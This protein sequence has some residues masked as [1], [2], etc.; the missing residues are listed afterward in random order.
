[1]DSISILS[2]CETK[3]YVRIKR[4][5]TNE[6][7]DY[8]LYD[9][10]STC[11]EIDLATGLPVIE[12]AEYEI[13]V[14]IPDNISDISIDVDINGL[15]YIVDECNVD[16]L[17]ESIS[18]NMYKKYLVKFNPNVSRPFL[19][20]YGFVRIIVT[21]TSKSCIHNELVLTTKD[22]PSISSEDYQESL[23]SNM[24]SELLESEN[25]VVFNWMFGDDKNEQNFFSR[26]NS[27]LNE[28]SSKSLLSRIQ[29]FEK[30]IVE[31]ESDFDYFRL[32]GFS[33][34]IR[35]NEKLA[36][37]RIKR[38]GSQE[39][40]WLVK[41]S[42]VLQETTQ[43]TSINYLGKYYLPREIET[44]VKEKSY[45]SYENRLVLG[46]LEEL[47]I[48]AKSIY[49]NLKEKIIQT[50]DL[51]KQFGSFRREGFSLPA[52]V[53]VRQCLNRENGYIAKLHEVIN[54]LQKLKYKYELIM[55]S[56]KGVFSR[57]PRRTKVFQEIKCYSNIYE[58][59][60]K[61]LK[62]GDFTLNRENLA[63]HSLRLD[64][65]YEYYVLFKLLSSLS[66]FGFKE[67]SSEEI[68]I[69]RANYSLDSKYYKNEKRVATLYKLSLNNIHIKLYY[70]PVVYGDEREENGIMLHRLS[71]RNSK[72]SNDRDSY[73]VPDFIF[74]ITKKGKNAEWHIFDAKY[75]KIESLWEG[76]PKTGV[77]TEV[78]S[79]YRSD[80]QP[81]LPRDVIGSVWLFSGRNRDKYLRY[82]E[83]SSWA[84]LNFS[85]FH[86]GIGTL[87]P[88]HSCLNHILLDILKLDSQTLESVTSSNDSYNYAYRKTNSN[89]MIINRDK[90]EILPATL[91]LKNEKKCN[92]LSLIKELYNIIE[93][94][95][96]L[97]K[98]QWAQNNLGMAHPL[99][100]RTLPTGSERKF[101]TKEEICEESCFVFNKW[102]PNYLNKLM[103]YIDRYK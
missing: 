60:L 34:I 24:L 57:L 85:G 5:F 6:S 54:D 74:K 27:A 18:G 58:L 78:I 47:I 46:F 51:E 83:R 14:F 82:A 68:P 4:R 33:R 86:S 67:D 38:V 35:T 11:S 90:S 87:N 64:K 45:D 98:S 53:L 13:S 17:K 36:P 52:L 101:Y 28:Y 42:K 93:D 41:N 89:L 23:I 10:T 37:R 65:L 49:F 72:L 69:E 63:L 20:V 25:N 21:V 2:S 12:N 29:L 16:T 92:Y 91:I 59:I 80:I 40:L 32:H 7:C 44:V 75:S 99:L 61:W 100:R 56:V 19:L 26:I 30:V 88:L 22:I 31:F 79:K 76:Y 77:F 71:C 9:F 39:L 1:M 95:N 102:L 81:S 55:P 84:K 103:H 66:E 70:Q 15:D 48:C 97:Y 62:F 94:K 8:V 3:G 96:L 73:W 50:Q 43:E